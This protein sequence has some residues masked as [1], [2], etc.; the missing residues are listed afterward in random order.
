MVFYAL[1]HAVDSFVVWG[2]NAQKKSLAD[3]ACRGRAA[4]LCR[5]ALFGRYA[6]SSLRAA[7]HRKPT[8]HEFTEEMLH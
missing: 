1:C 6:P 8:D 2:K 7:K 3:G 4:M 5:P